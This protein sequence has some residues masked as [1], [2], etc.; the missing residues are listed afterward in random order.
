MKALQKSLIIVAI[1]SCAACEK[2]N[3]KPNTSAALELPKTSKHSER[4]QKAKSSAIKELPMQH[5]GASAAATELIGAVTPATLMQ[6]MADLERSALSKQMI[7]QYKLGAIQNV[8]RQDGHEQVL[9]YLKE[10]VPFGKDRERMIEIAFS[11]YGAKACPEMIALRLSLHPLDKK[12]AATGMLDAIV[13]SED[14][15][16]DKDLFGAFAEIKNRILD[17]DEVHMLKELAASDFRD[18]PFAANQSDQRIYNR[19]DHLYAMQKEGTIGADELGQI[20][21]VCAESQPKIAWEQYQKLTTDG[22]SIP[23]KNTEELLA[24]MISAY[25][26]DALKMIQADR[27]EF[28]AE[29]WESIGTALMQKNSND[30]SAWFEENI[31]RLN[32]DAANHLMLAFG[33][34]A[35]QMEDLSLAKEWLAKLHDENVAN[36]LSKAVQDKEQEVLRLEEDK[37]APK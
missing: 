23:N 20:L 35:L 25:S 10:N 8:C 24:N 19:F 13:W 30:A 28:P 32:E 4:N 21:S 6:C 17:D 27:L 36:H 14:G 5:D 7:F 9:L 2:Q 33:K 11:E 18:D 16:F 37:A 34:H 29:T 26:T 1:I 15:A 22:V 3:E 31:S 12:A